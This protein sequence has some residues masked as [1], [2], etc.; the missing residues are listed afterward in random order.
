[1]ANDQPDQDIVRHRADLQKQGWYLTDVILGEGGGGKAV[2]SIKFDALIPLLL[3]QGG[4]HMAQSPG[5]F[6][7]IGATVLH[8]LIT[9]T[10]SPSP[11]IGVFKSSKH[12]GGRMKRE[13]K[14]LS[15]CKHPNLVQIYTAD[16][17]DE[18]NWYVM[19]YFQKGDL[20]RNAEHYKGNPLEVLK[21][22]RELTE[23]LAV[24][25]ANKLIHRD[26]KPEN[27]FVAD[28]GRWVLGDFGIAFESGRTRH[29]EHGVPMTKDWRPDWVVSR[30]LEE[31][32]PTVDLF[33]LAKVIYA[34][35]AGPGQNPP[36]SQIDEP[37]FDLRVRFPN[38]PFISEVH[39]FIAGHVAT[40]ERDMQSSTARDFIARLDE[41]ISKFSKKTT[42]HHVFSHMA[43]HPLNFTDKEHI[44]QLQ[45]I[46]IYLPE[47]TRLI[48]VAIRLLEAP[49]QY[50]PQISLSITSIETNTAVSS[51]SKKVFLPSPPESQLGTW[52]TLEMDFL[53]T[54]PLR[55]NWYQFDLLKL[56]SAVVTALILNAEALS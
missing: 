16:Q 28:D 29:T 40:R 48:R 4:P 21:R 52:L 32:P 49:D 24:V 19:E 1:M 38:S 2:L 27:I 51:F 30:R 23:A 47:G 15:G 26:I 8:R 13:I 53:S 42:Q 17:S 56:N 55:A 44:T 35:I 22:A 50:S 18:P 12:A 36:A 31:Y 25:H 46:P 3:L 39:Q 33:L 14:A 41:L 37:E 20:T 11:D 34:L 7:K 45:D 5:D 9:T 6:H 54:K 10:R 43:T